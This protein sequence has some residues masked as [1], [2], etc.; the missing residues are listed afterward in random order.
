MLTFSNTVQLLTSL[1]LF[2]ALTILALTVPRSYYFS[3]T[4]TFLARSWRRYKTNTSLIHKDFS[5]FTLVSPSGGTDFICSPPEIQRQLRDFT[6]DT[7]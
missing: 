5:L 6:M 1:L 4:L 3:L 2:L 7:Q